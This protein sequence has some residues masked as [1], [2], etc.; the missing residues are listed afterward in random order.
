MVY[1]GVVMAFMTWA[2]ARFTHRM[3]TRAIRLG[4][5]LVGVGSI[6]MLMLVGLTIAL[7]LSHVAGAQGVVGVLSGMYSPTYLVAIVCLCV[8]A[9]L[10][11]V[12]R[13]VNRRHR[14]AH[15]ARLKKELEGIWMKLQC[16]KM[17][18]SVYE[19][20]TRHGL[21]FDPLAV[22]HRLL[23][24]IEDRRFYDPTV[25]HKLTVRDRVLLREGEEL[26]KLNESFVAA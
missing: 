17:T 12:S 4:F 5:W 11:P 25:D 7:N 24:E 8:G 19:P 3:S 21:G 26:V 15:A 22:I 13:A 18:S 6:A 1:V 2:C 14:A 20:G 23:I 16:D 9:G 10:P